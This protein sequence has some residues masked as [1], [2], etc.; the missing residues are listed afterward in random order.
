[1]C[2]SFRRFCAAAAAVAGVVSNKELSVAAKVGSSCRRWWGEDCQF[3]SDP[4]QTIVERD[5]MKT[6]AP[7]AAAA[8]AVVAAAPAAHAQALVTQPYQTLIVQP[9]TTVI[10]ETPLFAV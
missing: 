8:F 6:F 1:M 2:R 4:T 10:R 7:L 9:G 3:L 5:S